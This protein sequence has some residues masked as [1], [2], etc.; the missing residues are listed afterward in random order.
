VGNINDELG[1]GV[2]FSLKLLDKGDKKNREY[3]LRARNLAEAEKWYEKLSAIKDAAASNTIQEEDE[4]S[5]DMDIKL[6]GST[7]YSSCA[8]TEP[9]SADKP[10]V[11]SDKTSAGA[12]TCCVIQ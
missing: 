1:D 5:E 2:I 11:T 6:I 4:E 8:N 7:P 9:S 12:C 3:I 10:A